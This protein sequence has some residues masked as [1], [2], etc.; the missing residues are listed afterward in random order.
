MILN[1]LRELFQSLSGTF[2]F[3][4]L[5][6]I[7]VVTWHVPSIGGAAL[8]AFCGIVPA[9]LAIAEHREQLA[10]NSKIIEKL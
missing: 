7:A 5:C 9:V 1:G 4:T 6:V 3:I 8:V 2:A 10:S